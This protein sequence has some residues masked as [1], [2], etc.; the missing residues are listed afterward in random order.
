MKFLKRVV[1]ASLAVMVV[2]SLLPP[3]YAVDNASVLTSIGHSS[4]T[5]LR[6]P[7]PSAM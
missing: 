7:P 5:P 4:P 6:F 1:A 3:V 2:I